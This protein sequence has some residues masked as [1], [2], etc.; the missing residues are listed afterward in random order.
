MVD[1]RKDIKKEGLSEYFLFT[2]E[3]R[4]DIQ[5]KQPKRLVSMKVADVPLEVIYKL[6]DRDGGKQFAKFYRFKNEKLLD[7]DGNERE[8]DFGVQRSGEMGE[9][10]R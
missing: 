4:E 10:R 9:G 8:F 7:D 3:G 2:I 6:T 1:A 5:D